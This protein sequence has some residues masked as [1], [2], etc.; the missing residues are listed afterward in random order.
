MKMPIDFGEVDQRSEALEPLDGI[1]IAVTNWLSLD[2]LGTFVIE[3]RNWIGYYC[4]M[5]IDFG[6]CHLK[7]K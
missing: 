7:W 6:I 4:K 5:S 1:R 3:L 2:I